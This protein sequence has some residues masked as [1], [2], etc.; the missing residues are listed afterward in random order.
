MFP[1]QPQ[2]CIPVLHR[3]SPRAPA[4]PPRKGCLCLQPHVWLVAG[5]LLDTP[6]SARILH[7]LRVP[8]FKRDAFSVLLSLSR[9]AG[10]LC[11]VQ[12]VW[13]WEQVSCLPPSGSRSLLY[14][15]SAA[16]ACPIPPSGRC[17]GFSPPVVIVEFC[18]SRG[19]GQAG[20]RSGE[21]ELCPSQHQ[22]PFMYTSSLEWGG[23]GSCTFPS[24]NLLLQEKFL[25]SK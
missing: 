14:V 16:W 3:G 21:I 20:E 19:Q 24:V 25:G 4:S 23:R 6:G 13:V 10:R 15:I 5:A 17:F 22:M 7:R 18:L 11:R 9:V 1:L 2:S 12:V 8:R